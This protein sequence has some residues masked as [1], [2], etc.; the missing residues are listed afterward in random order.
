MN[1]LFSLEKEAVR[2]FG[3]T[4]VESRSSVDGAQKSREDAARLEREERELSA[5]LKG[6]SMTY[7]IVN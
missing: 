1:D 4:G 7:S 2:E 6:K 5:I 3:D